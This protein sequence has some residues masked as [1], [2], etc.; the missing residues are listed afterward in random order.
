MCFLYLVAKVLMCNKSQSKIYLWIIRC[1]GFSSSNT[2]VYDIGSWTCPIRFIDT[3]PSEH[4]WI[5]QIRNSQK[6]ESIIELETKEELLSFLE[7]SI[8]STLIMLKVKR[9]S[10]LSSSSKN[11]DSYVVGLYLP[12]HN[13]EKV[14]KLLI[15]KFPN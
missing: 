8:D 6:R 2:D 15:P 12:E 10:S 9:N 5:N 7:I 1:D 13:L 11:W 4:R 3:F 14:N